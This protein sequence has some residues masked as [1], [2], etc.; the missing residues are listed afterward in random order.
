MTT[1]VKIYHIVGPISSVSNTQ[2]GIET[3]VDPVTG[4]RMWGGKDATGAITKWLALDKYARVT[5]LKATTTVETPLLDLQPTTVTP[6]NRRVFW[7]DDEADLASHNAADAV[8]TIPARQLKAPLCI[9]D[10]GSPILTGTPCVVNTAVS[11]KP[12]LVPAS[13]LTY[14]FGDLV[15]FPMRDV[16]DG[17]VVDALWVG[18]GENLDTSAFPV[19]SALYLSDTAGQLTITPPANPIYVGRCVVSSSTVGRILYVGTG[20]GG[21]LSQYYNIQNNDATDIQMEVGDH[22]VQHLLDDLIG[23]GH[24]DGFGYTDDGGGSCTIATGD[25]YLHT[26]SLRGSTGGVFSIPGA[27]FTLTDGYN[28]Y[29]YAEYNGGSPRLQ[30]TVNSTAIRYVEDKIIVHV[31]RRDGAVLRKI[32][33]SPGWQSIHTVLSQRFFEQAEGEGDQFARRLKGDIISTA[34]TRNPTLSAGVYGAGM[35]RIE[36]PLIDCTAGGTFTQFYGDSVNGWTYNTGQTQLN[37]TQYYN[38]AGGLT[39]LNTARYSVRWVWRLF[40]VT[41]MYINI[42]AT[43]IIDQADAILS[44]IPTDLP[45]LI[46]Q[47]GQLVGRHIVQQGSNTVLSLP[48]WTT[49]LSS[50]GVIAHESTVDKNSEPGFQHY[51]QSPAAGG[52]A[53]EAGESD[54]VT[55]STLTASVKCDNQQLVRT[56]GTTYAGRYVAANSQYFVM[57]SFNG[58]LTVLDKFSGTELNTLY[59][60]SSYF[61]PLDVDENRVYMV[62]AWGRECYTLPDLSVVY[63]ETDA[64]SINDVCACSDGYVAAITSA[65]TAVNK[66]APDG[67][68]SDTTGALPSLLNQIC[69]FKISSGGNTMYVLDTKI[70]AV[71]SAVWFRVYDISTFTSPTLTGSV[72]L[73]A[74]TQGELYGKIGY[75]GDHIAVA[76]TKGGNTAGVLRTA[77]IN[78]TAPATPTLVSNVETTQVY[79]HGRYIEDGLIYSIRSGSPNSIDVY[80]LPGL[81]TKN[82]GLVNADLRGG[83]I[84]T[85]GIDSIA[86]PQDFMT[87][88]LYTDILRQSHLGATIESVETTVPTPADNKLYLIS[89]GTT[90]YNG[91]VVWNS[92]ALGPQ[93]IPRKDHS[94]FYCPSTKYTYTW[95]TDRWERTFDWHMKLNIADPTAL[96]NSGL[97]YMDLSESVLPSLAQGEAWEI[98]ILITAKPIAGTY[99]SPPIINAGKWKFD[100]LLSYDDSG[101]IINDGASNPSNATEVF[102][103]SVI[104]DVP[105]VGLNAGALEITCG[106]TYPIATVTFEFSAIIR[107]RVSAVKDGTPS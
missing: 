82:E 3:A 9:N 49:T 1:E 47:F 96:G 55:S 68:L 89:G 97:L 101:D 25:A 43:N 85:R 22:D 20:F 77:L 57:I 90:V 44:P 15:V 107:G 50:S 62:G 26:N 92:T 79:T 37:N 31:I 2:F 100:G 36:T 78:V 4:F 63:D 32:P 40:S 6:V 29:I 45:P 51:D 91:Y 23:R 61:G 71:A 21:N 5:T 33:F 105:T 94:S 56:V 52:T 60:G 67:T 30:N 102:T 14:A 54:A 64:L 19:D 35:N 11:G 42:S 41:E 12:A 59:L 81:T 69:A 70:T 17:A 84:R 13:A 73:T 86:T 88:K 18:M 72:A 27:S 104:Y 99:S 38:G 103:S 87:A 66:Y 83:I 24:I 98:E 93:I 48:R 10:T 39:S 74:T 16:P 80:K 65:G 34:G 46:A 95:Q 58:Y 76:Y 7:D 53:W 75:R 8:K 106:V 28:N